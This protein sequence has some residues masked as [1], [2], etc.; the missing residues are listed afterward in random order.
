MQQWNELFYLFC[1]QKQKMLIAQ[2]KWKCI[3]DGIII[4]DVIFLFLFE[5]LRIEFIQCYTPGMERKYMEFVRKQL[6]IHAKFST[7]GCFHL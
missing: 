1:L 3:C 6:L 4:N 7:S 5:R 2:I